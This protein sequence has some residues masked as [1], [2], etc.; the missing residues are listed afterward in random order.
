[1]SR[2]ALIVAHGQPSDPNPA[3]ADLAAVAKAVA[4]ELPGW[5]IGSATLAAPDALKN[6]LQELDKPVIFPF[7][8]ADGW[9]IRSLLPRRLAEAGA[10]G[11]QILPPFGLRR[12]TTDLAIRIVRDTCAVAGWPE[13]D[14]TL[15]LAAHGSGRSRAPAEAARAIEAAI[16]GAL[17]LAGI[18][19][20]FIEEP[21][22]LA[23][24]A[25]GA[26]PR[27]LCLP[28]FVARWGH[29]V[30]DIPAELAEAGYTGRLLD[31]IGTHPDV[32]ALIAGALRAA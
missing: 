26:G 23:E 16:A 3:E 18:R 25:L 7:F 8:M 30:T 15:I 20:G 29:V 14:T 27:S 28:L 10:E 19:T 4:R 12:E 6:A 2:S 13:T 32:P 1:M 21:P 17:T 22:G 5:R 24:A 9:F 31:P 11:L